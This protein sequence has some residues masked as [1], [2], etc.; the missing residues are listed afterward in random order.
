VG[1]EQPDAAPGGRREEPGRRGLA[2]GA[3]DRDLVWRGLAAGL[4]PVA[5]G[6]GIGLLAAALVARVSVSLLPG[7]GVL[8]ARTYAAVAVMMICCAAGAGLSAAWRLR[9]LSPAEALRAE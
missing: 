7:L 2:L 3:T 6:T 5:T 8:E 1:A 9:R 4:T